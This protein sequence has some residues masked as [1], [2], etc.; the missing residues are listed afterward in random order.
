MIVGSLRNDLKRYVMENNIYKDM[1]Q[2]EFDTILFDLLRH[3]SG[4]E[5][6]HI[7]GIYEILAEE[8][9]N[10]VLQ[11]WEEEYKPK[12]KEIEK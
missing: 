7:E 11:I 10:D 12:K 5:L 2:D 6:L 4:E 3:C 9:N 1:T 8:F